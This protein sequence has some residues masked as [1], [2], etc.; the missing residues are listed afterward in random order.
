MKNLIILTL[1][2]I[3][4]ISC[5][6]TTPYDQETADVITQFY[7]DALGERESYNLLRDLSKDIGH[8]PI[9]YILHPLP[10]IP[11]IIS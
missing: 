2:P 11:Y 9:S 1:I 8:I 6:T 3:L 4:I 7:G 10:Y 5:E